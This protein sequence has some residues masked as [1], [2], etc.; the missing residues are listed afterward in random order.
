MS[1]INHR[2]SMFVVWVC[3]VNSFV[4]FAQDPDN[5]DA[6]R[7]TLTVPIIHIKIG[8]DKSLEKKQKGR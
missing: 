6:F 3:Y 8:W 2:P 4:K 5:L 1:I 7:M